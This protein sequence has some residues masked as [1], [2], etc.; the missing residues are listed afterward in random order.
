MP[1]NVIE[2]T[3]PQLPPKL[4]GPN[5]NRKN[6]Q[7]RSPLVKR[8]KVEFSMLLEII[9]PPHQR[10]PKPLSQ[11]IFHITFGIAGRIRID[12]VNLYGRMKP[13]EDVLVFEHIIL[14]DSFKVIE[15]VHLYR[16]FL[17][18]SKTPYT[19]WYIEGVQ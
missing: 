6:Y 4:I 9:Y 18:K 13:W 16:N 2:W 12:P 8:T 7:T 17:P 3:I 11:C 5:N 1:T 14:D 10:L 15:E 19:H